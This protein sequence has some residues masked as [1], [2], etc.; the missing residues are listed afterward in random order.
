LLSFAWQG[1]FL[2]QALIGLVRTALSDYRKVRDELGV[3]QYGEAE[4]LELLGD[5]GFAAERRA[6]N[7]GH[8]QSRMTFVATP[9]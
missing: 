4:M 3:A 7:I 6:R 9:A 5:C 8:N 2:R 1:G